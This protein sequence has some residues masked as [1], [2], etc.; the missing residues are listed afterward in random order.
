[1]LDS[2]RNFRSLPLFLLAAVNAP[3]RP[4]EGMQDCAFLAVP[5]VRELRQPDGRAIELYFRG[6]G[7]NHWYEDRGGFP[8]V[9]TQA[10]YVFARRAPDG[11]LAATGALVGTVD[12]RR[13][14]LARKVV[15]VPQHPRS[16]GLAAKGHGRGTGDRMPLTGTV[17]NLV[18]LLRY[19][20]HGPSGQNRTLPSTSD[21]TTI[22]NAVGGDPVL[23]PTGSVRDHWVGW[24]DVPESETY[25]A[26]GDSGLTTLTWD[27]ITDGLDAADAVVDFT[28]FDDDG[29]GWVDA[30]TFLHSGY[31]AEWGGDDDYGTNYTDRMWSHKWTIPTWT[32]AEGVQVGDYNI[33]P[34]LWGVS[35]SDPGRI[36]VVCHELAHFFGL[37]DLYDTDGSSGGIGFW[38]LLAGGSWGWDGSQQYPSHLCA[39][40]KMKLGWVVPQ[41]IVPGTY[42]AQD[43][44]TNADLYM[45]DSGYP[46]G[47]YLLIENR[48]PV[49]F[50]ALIPQGGLAVWH[51][52]EGKGSFTWD[53]PNNDEGYPGQLGWPENNSHYRVALLQADGFFDN[54]FGSWGDDGDLYRSPFATV[55]DATTTPDTDAYQ[56][57]SIVVNSNRLQ[58]IAV[59]SAD[60]AFTYVNSSAPVITTSNLPAADLGRRYVRNLTRTGGTSPFTWTEFLEEPSYTLTDLGA[61]TFV[62]GGTAQGFNADED[63]W[64]IDLPFLFPWY[65][66]SYSRVYVNPNGCVDLAP[67]ENESYNTTPFL[68]CFPRIA[69]LWDDLVTD[70]AAGQDIYLDTSVAGQARIRWEA[71][72]YASGLPANFAITLYQDGRIRFDYGSG[73][74]GLTPTV[75]LSRGHSGDFLLATTHD[76]ESALTDASSLELTLEGSQL[77]PGL[78]LSP[79]GV[80]SGIPTVPG[81]HTFVVRVRDASGRYD[82]KSLTLKVRSRIRPSGP[83]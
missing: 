31:G 25:Y 72:P 69:G 55:L 52:D 59:S 53:D 78:T 77:P 51:V 26:N 62:A 4:L 21:V 67:L 40:A 76:G 60:M 32:S 18:L 11:R 75:G 39:W 42:S 34:A 3:A 14:G 12:P 70:A 82:Q 58:G 74:T 9:E 5:S 43:I 44:E 24:L 63:T 41:R 1:M 13:L 19:S 65:E 80:L 2:L 27:L 47:E 64:A 66:T 48:Q 30:I 61:Q 8:V 7:A 71:E 49:G 45:I 37:P 17:K 35:G 10:G 81:S 16:A 28:D 57:G 6:D 79:G 68:S 36:G 33:S 29:D 73:N 20:D 56:G 23:A 46:S 22:M 54:E 50:D 83:P 38:C 15:P